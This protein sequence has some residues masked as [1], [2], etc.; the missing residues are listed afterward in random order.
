MIRRLIPFLGKVFAATIFE[1][2]GNCDNELRL[3]KWLVRL[4]FYAE[5]RIIIS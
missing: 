1:I 4:R 3:S 5:V 2:V